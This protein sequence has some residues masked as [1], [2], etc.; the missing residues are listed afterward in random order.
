MKLLQFIAEQGKA[1]PD[2]FSFATKMKIS[3]VNIKATISKANAIKISTSET[4]VTLANLYNNM[5]QLMEMEYESRITV[6]MFI[7]FC[8]SCSNKYNFCSKYL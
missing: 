2:K 3:L 5:K 7:Y 8:S 4:E 1:D 6:Y